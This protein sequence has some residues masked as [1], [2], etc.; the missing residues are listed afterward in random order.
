ME[1]VQAL[2]PLWLDTCITSPKPPTAHEARVLTELGLEDVTVSRDYRSTFGRVHVG[3]VVCIR[4]DDADVRIGEVVLFVY[5]ADTHEST[6]I[7]SMWLRDDAP[8]AGH[9]SR[10]F[11]ACRG[12]AMHNVS[13]IECALT[14]SRSANDVALVLLPP[15]YRQ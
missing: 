5:R 3:D 11:A 14:Y 9:T 15:K 8:S 4:G 7:M 13:L 10:M 6:V 12:M 2:E 1:Q